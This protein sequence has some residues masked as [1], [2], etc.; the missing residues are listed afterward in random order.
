MD[1]Y[2]TAQQHE[3]NTMMTQ[4]MLCGLSGNPQQYREPPLV[5]PFRQAYRAWSGH[6]EPLNYDRVRF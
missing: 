4:P 6:G 3:L 2:T 5:G 1:H